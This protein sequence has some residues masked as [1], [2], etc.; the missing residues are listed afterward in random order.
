MSLL[1]RL[2]SAR[3][4]SD[5]DVYWSNTVTQPNNN[6]TTSP[7]HG[8]AV[9]LQACH[10]SALCPQP[11]HHCTGAQGDDTNSDSKKYTGAHIQSNTQHADASRDH[12]DSARIHEFTRKRACCGGIWDALSNLSKGPRGG[13]M[14]NMSDNLTSSKKGENLTSVAAAAGGTPARS[15][16]K[17]YY[18]RPNRD[19]TCDVMVVFVGGRGRELDGVDVILPQGAALGFWKA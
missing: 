7:P 5:G 19:D 10:P 9:T 14:K 17:D 13:T 15:T 6:I 4:D 2:I 12:A 1:S 11:H 18:L 3:G 8:V 16:R